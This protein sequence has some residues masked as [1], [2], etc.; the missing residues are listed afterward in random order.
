MKRT[1]AAVAAT[2][3]L[4]IAGLAPA[5]TH[6]VEPPVATPAGTVSQDG[7]FYGMCDFFPGWCG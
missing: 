2:M 1:L 3:T 7:F 5:P 6:A 4:F